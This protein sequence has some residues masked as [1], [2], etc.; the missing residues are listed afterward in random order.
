VINTQ[1]TKT[2]K[3]VIYYCVRYESCEKA[4]YTSTPENLPNEHTEQHLI[5]D[6]H[7]FV[8]TDDTEKL[9][10]E[11]SKINIIAGED[12]MVDSF[13]EQIKLGDFNKAVEI[14]NS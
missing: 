9:L 11:L 13:I 12:E 1:K 8:E 2:K 14:W 10:S 6:K 4:Y 3:L 7:V 5:F